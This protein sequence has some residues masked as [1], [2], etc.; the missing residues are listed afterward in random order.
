MRS[1]EKEVK[2]HI[3][4]S[5]VLILSHVVLNVLDVLN[6]SCVMLFCARRQNKLLEGW[7]PAFIFHPKVSFQFRML[8]QKN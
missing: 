3:S 2:G 8:F 5:P 1:D 7:C 4:F 6:L